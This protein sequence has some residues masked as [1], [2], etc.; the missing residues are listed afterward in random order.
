MPGKT[1]PAVLG[2]AGLPPLAPVL[3]AG[4][5]AKPPR[6]GVNPVIL[7]LFLMAMLG[8]VAAVAWKVLSS[9]TVEP[10]VV[11][12]TERRQAQ[13]AQTPE[14]AP[15]PGAPPR[16]FAARRR[17]L[18]LT[19]PRPGAA[20]TPAPP[21]TSAP[22]PRRQRRAQG[23]SRGTPPRP[24]RVPPPP[25]KDN[26]AVVAALRRGPACAQCRRL[27]EAERAFQAVLQ[28]Q[29]GFRDTA[30][31]ARA[32]AR[33]PG[34]RRA[35]RPLPT[36]RAFEASGDWPRAIAAYERAGAADRPALRGRR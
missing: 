20:R 30:D 8:A 6:K 34:R 26:P 1:Q 9:G 31:V 13:P 10:R 23:R 5:K 14:P 22:P 18:R 11:Q 7:V 32:G 17:R 27:R 2:A 36:A 28:Q 16:L 35:R 24:K 33:R 29:P 19:S 12:N 15:P 4:V 21:T 25:P 3:R